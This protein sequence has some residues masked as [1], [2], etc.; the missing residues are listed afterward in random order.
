MNV[1]VVY[2]WFLS[3]MGALFLGHEICMMKNDA[4]ILEHQTRLKHCHEAI[5]GTYENTVRSK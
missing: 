1:M 5:M 4:I 2:T 3:I